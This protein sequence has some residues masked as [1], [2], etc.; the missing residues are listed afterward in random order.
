MLSNY[1]NEKLIQLQINASN[2]EDAIRKAASVLI[3]NKKVK[4]SYVD[5]MVRVA[6]ESSYIV[7]T[8]HVALPHARPETGA[9]E[10]AIGITTLQKPI[11]FGNKENDPV[12]YIFA[13]SAVDN[14][15]HLKAM[16]ELAGLLEKDEFYRLLDRARDSKVVM[17]YIRNFEK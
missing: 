7:I 12:K 16:A 14:E 11:V 2:R 15:S 17:D 8:K 5:D 3:E 13:L 1:T 4:Q 10:S 6:E 9:I